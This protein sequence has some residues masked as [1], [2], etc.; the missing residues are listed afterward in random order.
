MILQQY[1][2]KSYTIKIEQLYLCYNCLD[3]TWLNEVW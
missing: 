1:F 3:F 2:I